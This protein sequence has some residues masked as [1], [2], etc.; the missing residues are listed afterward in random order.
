MQIDKL[1]EIDGRWYDEDLN[2]VILTQPKSV[3]MNDVTFTEGESYENFFGTCTVVALSDEKMTVRYD[4][5]KHTSV[6][7]GDE[8]TYPIAAQADTIAKERRRVKA[9]M[10][11]VNAMEFT[12]AKD[13]DTLAFI[14]EH[15]TIDV[16]VPPHRK[17]LFHS[18]YMSVAGHPPEDHF[19]NGF[20]HTDCEG[21]WGDTMRVYL[22]MPEPEVAEK[23]SL[24]EDGVR[25]EGDR[26]IVSN[27]S[28]VWGL[29][30]RGFHIG[31]NVEN[32]KVRV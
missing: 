25:V 3:T 2:E 9:K 5:V 24:P 7:V 26:I 11:K 10:S 30:H 20:H 15:G 6:N 16:T 27:N 4:E 17:E 1:V 32:Q 28:F 29:F 14:K 22:P 18:R 23:L 21:W 8:R 12:G 19:G 31:S 13:I